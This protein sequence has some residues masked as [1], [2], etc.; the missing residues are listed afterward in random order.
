[1]WELNT[2]VALLDGRRATRGSWTALL[3]DKLADLG[4]LEH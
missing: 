3:L 4:D 2:P 1:V